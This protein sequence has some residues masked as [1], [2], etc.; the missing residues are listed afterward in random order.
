MKRFGKYYYQFLQ[1]NDAL[2]LQ[3]N[4]GSFTWDK[5]LTRIVKTFRRI[6]KTNLLGIYLKQ[7]LKVFYLIQ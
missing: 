2:W 4:W 3:L 1:R 5:L 6:F 7:F